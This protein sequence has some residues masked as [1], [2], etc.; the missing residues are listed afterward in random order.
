MSVRVLLAGASLAVLGSVAA[1]AAD[2]IIPTTP[3]PIYE[4]AGFDWEGLYVGARVGG[5]FV[6]AVSGGTTY[7]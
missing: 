7:A 6:G 2:L 1:Q 4:A 5:Q 3:E